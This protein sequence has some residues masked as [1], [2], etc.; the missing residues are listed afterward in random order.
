MVWCHERCHK[1]DCQ[2]Q[3]DDLQIAAQT[4][5]ASM[6]CLKKASRFALCLSRQLRHPYG[7]VTDWREAKPCMSVIMQQSS[8][9]YPSLVVVVCQSQAQFS[10]ASVWA[11][12]QVTCLVHVCRFCEPSCRFF[13]SLADQIGA[14]VTHRLT[15]A[16]D[17]SWSG[18][19]FASQL[20]DTRTGE[21][22]PIPA[23]PP[24]SKT[25]STQST[26]P[27][28]G[29]IYVLDERLLGDSPHVSRTMCSA[30]NSSIDT[31]QLCHE[32]TDHGFQ[33]QISIEYS[34]WMRPQE[35]KST[36][37]GK[38]APLALQ[39]PWAPP[40]GFDNNFEESPVRWSAHA[41]DLNSDCGAVSS[42]ELPL[43]GSVGRNSPSNVCGHVHSIPSLLASV[44]YEEASPSK[45]YTAAPSGDDILLQ[46]WN[47]SLEI[48]IPQAL[49]MVNPKVLEQI[50]LQAGPSQYDD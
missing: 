7:V 3:R 46:L 5:G 24:C 16:V 37:D 48:A 11:S 8:M 45:C 9:N 10:R 14:A 19:S 49:K 50:L 28:P 47:M 29:T 12:K 20:R 39:P 30:E 27:N 21:Y 2:T 23:N 13:A 26:V 42:S 32:Q 17:K 44:A 18:H 36:K 33:L 38:L 25:T 31:D 1:L 41:S 4:L 43:L 40:R 35:G 34:F 22:I 15:Q 6:V